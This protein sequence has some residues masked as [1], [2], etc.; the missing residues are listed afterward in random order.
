MTGNA[1]RIGLDIRTL[2]APKTGDRTYTLNLI[3]AL[4]RVDSRNGYLL[5][6]DRPV[7]GSLLPA[8]DNFRLVVAPARHP[9]WW[10]V[11]VLPRLA[12]ELRLDLVHVQYLA[13][14]AGPAKLLTTVHDATFAVLPETF[15]RRDRLLLRWLL[16]LTFRRAAHVLTG[17]E[18]SKRDLCRVFGL[19]AARVSV[20]PYAPGSLCGTVAPVGVDEVRRALQLPDRFVLSVG[21]LQPRKN[22]RRLIE[23]YARAGRSVAE[24]EAVPPLLIAG[25][26]GWLFEDILAAPGDFG[27]EDRVRFLD[28]VP[29]AYLPSLYQLAELFVFPSLYEGFGL[30]PLEAMAQGCPVLASSASCL[31]EVLGEAALFVDPVDVERLSEALL[32]L[33]RDADLRETYRQRG[34]A[35]V[36]RYSWEETARGTLA[37]YRKVLAA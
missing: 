16:P 6:S 29:D 10:T 2:T 31:P 15:P 7:D 37:V 8:A 23:A 21:V 35:Q 34:Y 17:T 24:S 9:Y 28:H 36:K 14:S 11:R 25:K 27:V 22:Y 33:L 26:R 18:V 13:W 19:E 32:Q 3:H 1:L 30:P 5:L 4:A 12:G 20:V